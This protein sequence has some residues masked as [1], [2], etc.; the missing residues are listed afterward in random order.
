MSVY[1]GECISGAYQWSQLVEI[2]ME[3]G[4]APP[5]LVTSTLYRWDDQKLVDLIGKFLWINFE[6]K[7]L[8]S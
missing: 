1:A 7:I 4:F 2:A 8:Y 3:I 6:Y 5:V